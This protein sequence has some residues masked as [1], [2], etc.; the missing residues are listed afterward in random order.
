MKNLAN[1]KP[2]EF[3]AQT[4]KIKKTVKEWMDINDIMK[5]RKTVPAG[6]IPLDNLKG[7]ERIAAVAHNK[8]LVKE[9]GMKNFDMILDKVLGENPEKTLEVLALCCFVDPK[10]VD[11][12]PMSEYLESIGELLSDQGVLSFFTSL[13]Q[14]GQKNTGIV[15]KQ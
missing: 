1:C 9:Q 7:E 15:P 12:H 10:D 6:L 13:V 4:I 3:L 14:L 11:N 5:L 2:S 8:K